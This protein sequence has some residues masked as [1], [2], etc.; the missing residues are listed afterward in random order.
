MDSFCTPEECSLGV[1]IVSPFILVTVWTQ[2]KV[3]QG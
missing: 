1:V 3:Y 2:N